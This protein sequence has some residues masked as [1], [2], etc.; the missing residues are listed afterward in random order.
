MKQ[1][2]DEILKQR[3]QLFPE[4]PVKEGCHLEYKPVESDTYDPDGDGPVPH[5]W[6]TSLFA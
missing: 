2:F 1:L 4:T 6:E 3:S 5:R